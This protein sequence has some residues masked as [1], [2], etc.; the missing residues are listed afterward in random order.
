MNLSNAEKATL[1]KLSG[2]TEL[3]AGQLTDIE[4][5]IFMDLTNKGVIEYTPNI[6]AG[7]DIRINHEVLER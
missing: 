6:D 3:Y 1:K 5:M 4:Y 7:L 2:W